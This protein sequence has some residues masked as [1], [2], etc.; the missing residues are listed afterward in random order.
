MKTEETDNV[1][2]D[3]VEQVIADYKDS[4]AANIKG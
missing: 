4:G 2:A 3:K 1:P